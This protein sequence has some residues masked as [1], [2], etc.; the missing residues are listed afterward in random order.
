MNHH[1]LFVKLMK[2][3][4]PV[5]ERL[6]CV[7]EHW[8]AIG[9]TCFSCAFCLPCG[10]RQGGVLSPYLFAIFIDSVFTR[11]QSYPFGCT[12]KWYCMSIFLY[13][14]DIVLLAP[15]ISAIQDLLH[16]CE[17]E[18]AW[19]DMSLDASK[20]TSMRIGPRYKHKCSELTTMDGHEI[21]WSN[22]IRYLGVYLASS[23]N[24]SILLDYAKKSFY[25]AFNGVF[26][27][28][29]RVASENVVV[30]LLNTKC[31]PILLY[32]LEACPLTKTQL[33]SLN[34]V[35]SSSFRKIF[36]VRSNE[37]VD[38]CRYM[39]HCS[40]IEDILSMRKKNF[41]QKYCSLENI[42]CVLC[43]N[44]A[45]VELA[46]LDTLTLSCLYP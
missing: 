10:V 5:P 18:L 45:D 41:L 22:A 35:I 26:G 32:W 23:K 40:N 31:L 34:Y 43:K 29:G 7:L 11:I 6:L 9:S 2:R 16:A 39:F 1:G 14:D 27:K 33:N 17:I 28:V 44:Q 21:P 4:V 13:A 25:R 8:F 30:E 37:I 42:L 15:S 38:F 24:F 36:N 19:L 3:R 20:T 12:V 46:S